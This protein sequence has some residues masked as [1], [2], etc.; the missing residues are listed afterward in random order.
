ME[1]SASTQLRF[2]GYFSRKYVLAVACIALS[3]YLV[4]ADKNISDWAILISIVLAFY[5]GANV[6]SRYVDQLAQKGGK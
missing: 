1:E 6:A 4:M 3:F 5:N 2:G